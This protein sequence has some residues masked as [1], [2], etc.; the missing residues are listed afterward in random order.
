[1]SNATDLV[2]VSVTL[3]EALIRIQTALGTAASEGRDVTDAEKAVARGHAV[4]AIKALAD[5]TRA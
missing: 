2:S 1:M 4:D 3:V 5:S